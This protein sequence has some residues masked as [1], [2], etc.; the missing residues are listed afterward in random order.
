MSTC[1]SRATIVD[2][3]DSDNTEEGDCDDPDYHPGGSDHRRHRIR[4]NGTGERCYSRSARSSRSSAAAT[5][6]NE[7]LHPDDSRTPRHEMERKQLGVRRRPQLLTTAPSI[8]A[9]P[10]HV[11]GPSQVDR[12]VFLSG[13]AAFMNSPHPKALNEAAKPVLGRCS[14]YECCAGSCSAAIDRALN[15]GGV[16]CASRV[17]V[18]VLGYRHRQPAVVLI[19]SVSNRGV[20]GRTRPGPRLP[21]RS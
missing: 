16:S 13:V 6:T 1:P 11:Y 9:K 15:S 10:S 12:R 5:R 3:A 14:W 18:L 2:T 4:T 17:T 8:N 21:N 19:M 7:L 20:Q